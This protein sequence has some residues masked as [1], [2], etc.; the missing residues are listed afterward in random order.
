MRSPARFS[1]RSLALTVGVLGLLLLAGTAAA[2]TPVN[3]RLSY[4]VF[5]AHAPWFVGLEKGWYRE[6]GLEVK[7]HPGR[8]SGEAVKLIGS[9]KEEFGVADAGAV[10]PGVARGVPIVTVMAPQQASALVLIA[11]ERSG[12]K[13]PQELRGHRM[14]L[15]VGST[16]AY[17]TKALLKKF[18]IGEEELRLISV[19]PGGETPLLLKN[20]I[21]AIVGVADNEVVMWRIR[22][23]DFR[24]RTWS[25][26]DLGISLYGHTLITNREFAARSPAAVRGF[27][28][29]GVR[30]WQYAI[31][32]PAEAVRAMVKHA[33]ELDEKVEL[34]KFRAGLEMRGFDSEDTRRHG[35]GW[36]SEEGWRTLHDVYLR[37]RVIERP[38]DVKTLFTNEFLPRR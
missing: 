26:K 4:L 32:N 1:S 5:G 9:G 34:A 11:T 30:A 28:A 3:L 14:G 17:M 33:S 37:E 38:L 2:A 15:Y 12:I 10:L 22:H 23:P 16:T 35:F 20:E 29:A 8:G 27:V 36:Q 21:E 6:A 25:M 24:F 13:A 18:G 7:I 31:A 19:K